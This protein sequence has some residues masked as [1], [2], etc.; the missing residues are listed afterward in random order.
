MDRS[1]DALLQLGGTPVFWSPARIG[2]E[3]AWWGHVPFAHWLVASL[4]PRCIVELG[5]HNGVSFAAFCEAVQRSGAST[6]CYAVDLWEGDEHAGHYGEEVYADLQPFI[7]SRFGTYAELMRMKFDEA[8]PYFEDG[9]VDLL[10]I[11]G[12]HTLEAVTADFESWRPKLSERGIVLFHD[13]NVRERGFGVWRLWEQL[14]DLYPS[15]EFLHGHGLG[16]LCVGAD[17]PDAMQL[18]CS[19]S[20]A[21]VHTVQEAFS[22]LGSRWIATNNADRAQAE[23]RRL[24]ARI[25]AL[26]QQSDPSTRGSEDFAGQLGALERLLREKEQQL[27]V[28]LSVAQVASASAQRV[29]SQASWLAASFRTA[30]LDSL[31]RAAPP[32]GGDASLP[33]ESS[34]KLQSAEGVML[35]GAARPLEARGY[36]RHLSRFKRSIEKRWPRML[37]RPQAQA[38]VLIPTPVGD[39]YAIVEDAASS[40]V[41][42][43]ADAWPVETAPPS[44]GMEGLSSDEVN[45][46]RAAF[47]EDYYLAN[48]PDIV[49]HHILPFDHFM[50]Y[51]WREERKPCADFDPA[52][53]LSRWSDIRKAGINPFVHWVLHGANEGRRAI[54]FSNSIDKS[55]YAPKIS[56][57]IPNYNH[58]RFL[59]Q[60]IE[61][62]LC[63]T[64]TNIEII[65]L[66]DCSTD[67]SRDI[68]D[69]YC[70]VYPDKIRRIFNTENSGNVFRQWH[71]GIGA[72]T[73][74]L[75]WI[76]ESDDFCDVDFI[77][78]LYP[79]FA[80]M[81]VSMAFG[82]I[83]YVD[84]EGNFA[85]GLDGYRERS[86]A[87]IW[88]RPLVRPAA[89]WFSKGFGV[90]NV[91][92]NVGGCLFRRSDIRPS[93]WAEAQTYHVVGDWLL[94]IEIA[95]GGQIAWDPKA[96]SYFRQHGKN[97]SS[98]AISK[99]FFYQEL[100][101]LML[102]L[103]KRWPVPDA[104]V[105]AFY[106][107]IVNQYKWLGLDDVYGDV[108]RYCSYTRLVERKR[109]TPHI[110]M[111]FLGF[112]PGGGELFPIN[113]ANELHQQGWLVSMLGFELEDVNGGMR[114]QLSPGIAVYDAE[115]VSE[116]GVDR[117]IREAGIS[118]VHSHTVGSEF[119]FFE[120]W[121]IE[122]PVPYLV[123]LHGSYEASDLSPERLAAL[124]GRVDYFVYTAEKNRHAISG[125]DIPESRFI[126]LPNAMPQDPK[127]FPLT[128]EQMNIPE[129]A[130]VFTLVARGIPSKGWEVCIKA[131][132]RLRGQNSGR[133]MHLLL[134]GEGTETDRLRKIHES[135]PDITFLGY[136]MNIHGLYR[137]SDVALVPSRFPGESFPLCIIQ[138]FQCGRP[139]IG[140]QIGEI[141]SMLMPAGESPG[142]MLI[143]VTDDD[144]LFIGSLVEAMTALLDNKTRYNYSISASALGEAYSMA[145]L[146]NVYGELYERLVARNGD[147]RS[148]SR[149]A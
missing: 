29:M 117:F 53:Y 145:K 9:F 59:T 13:I 76:C 148:P 17:V 143:P 11:D 90:N 30:F 124:A 42:T 105:E 12:L 139:V 18:L 119:R 75:I 84:P 87:G 10:H 39:A 140:S 23:C 83:L 130:I 88:G 86:E 15:F 25:D 43:L 52:Y 111:T 50:T 41:G 99:P 118:L 48:N 98:L 89:E 6:R 78:N 92:A 104:T 101:R 147:L 132:D 129:D 121:K 31:S 40:Q 58:A 114:S 56:A 46:L 3:S 54:P 133:P 19:L 34:P 115:W 109:Q 8:L 37:Y 77:Q 103:K 113:L 20:P 49:G 7:A 60:R 146:A 51:G 69:F 26:T 138:S 100:E 45:A 66:D 137:L 95:G 44:S 79:Y 125:I 35:A 102:T 120:Q 28:A 144:E 85:D 80:D 55:N 24:I 64:Y 110:L 126:K 62:I 27:E 70:S 82:R 22:S 65:I 116:Y 149:S 67:D 38:P 2:S 47:D 96:I 21:Q 91:I 33:R 73:G 93:I 107:H 61:S 142:G 57:I 127:P 97:T 1:L 128:R 135:D 36:R 94:Y 16:V 136:Q 63:Q 106:K 68:I 123:T 131:F 134:C 122:E 71:K 5:T 108:S 81:S 14:R 72:A 112:I 4:K 74:D 32:D 141:E